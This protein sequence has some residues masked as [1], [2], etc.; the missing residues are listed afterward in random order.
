MI[1]FLIV[2]KYHNIKP[3]WLILPSLKVTN[4][5]CVGSDIRGGVQYHRSNNF[6]GGKKSHS[7]PGGNQTCRQALPNRNTMQAH[8]ITKIS[9][10]ALL[11]RVKRKTWN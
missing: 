10:V 3:K 7:E 6:D 8:C 4:K 11:K 1:I 9:L 2:V 5:Y